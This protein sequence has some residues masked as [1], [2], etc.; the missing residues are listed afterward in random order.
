MQEIQDRFGG[1]DAYVEELA[2]ILGSPL[3]RQITGGI[4][5]ND[6]LVQPA[7]EALPPEWTAWWSSLPDHRL[8]Q[9]HLIDGIA[10]PASRRHDSTE[11][12]EDGAPPNSTASNPPES[13]NQWLARLRGASISRRQRVGVAV[14]LPSELAVRMNTK[15]KAEVAVAAAYIRDACAQNAV[16]HVIDMG[17]GQG[18]LSAT[19]AYLFPQL[20]VLAIDGSTSQ[21]AASRA[22]AASLGLSETRLAHLVRYVDGSAPLADEMATWAG[23]GSQRCILVGLHACGRLSEHMIRYYASLPFVV[24]LA[25]VGCCYNHLAPRSPA[26]PEGFPISALLQSKGIQLSPTGLMTGCQAPN[27][28]ETADAGREVSPFA[29]RRLYRAILEKLFHDQ[30]L[31]AD[32]REKPTWGI[33]KGDLA[34]FERFARR[35]MHCLGIAPEAVTTQTLE[36]YEQRYRHWEGPIAILWTLSILCCKLVESTIATD[37]YQYLLEQGA[38]NVDVVPIFDYG[39][40]PRNLMLV[41]GR[42]GQRQLR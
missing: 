4:H 20:R 12:G 39:I 18:Y 34:S 33:R 29:K 16:T 41:A 23:N 10:E 42:A 36:E 6:A 14:V 5:V 32:S 11:R 30:Q 15:K 9:Q 37:R 31:I 3:V 24:S 7:W 1:L 28:W 17:S 27:N 35:A 8:A 38:Q 22:F 21:V 40:S 2:E 19:L 13:L 25:A 26:C